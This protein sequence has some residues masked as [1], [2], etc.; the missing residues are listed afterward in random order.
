M[1]SA[2]VGRDA[3]RNDSVFPAQSWNSSQTSV[4]FAAV[5]TAF[6]MRLPKTLGRARA[7]G[8]RSTEAEEL[9]TRYPPTLELATQPVAVVLLARPAEPALLFV[10]VT[11]R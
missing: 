11:H 5:S 9:A 8:H 10:D 7:D 3:R 1:I 4:G 2:T 6:A